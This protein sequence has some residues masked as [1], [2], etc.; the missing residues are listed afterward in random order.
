MKKSPKHSKTISD[1][2]DVDVKL[3]KTRL[4]KTLLN[5]RNNTSDKE[6]KSELI[7]H[8]ILQLQEIVS[9]KTIL[10][11]YPSKSEVDISGLFQIFHKQG[12]SIFLPKVADFQIAKFTPK[13]SL[14]KGYKGI[15]EPE[16]QGEC[17]EHIDICILPGLGFDHFGNRIGHGGGWYDRIFNKI[18]FAKHIGVCFDSQLI[19]K[20][21]TEPHDKEVDFVIT[22]KKIINTRY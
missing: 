16:V 17:P 19:A 21:P 1:N 11:Y 18:K 2:L 6:N 7:V 12:K 8:K 3:Q 20:I 13:T 15:P 10:L 4:R 9:A 14:A 5:I 22:E